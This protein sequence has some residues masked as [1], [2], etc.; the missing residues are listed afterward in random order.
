MP[1]ATKISVRSLK[2]AVV[3]AVCHGEFDIAKMR[4]DGFIASDHHYAVLSDRIVQLALADPEECRK[5]LAELMPRIE[6]GSE[7]RG[8]WGK[9][10]MS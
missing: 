2:R 6:S 5:F 8:Y 4:V 1:T 7:C 3:E 9:Q 10:Q